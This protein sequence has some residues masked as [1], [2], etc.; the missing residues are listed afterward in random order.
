KMY[1]KAG[2]QNTTVDPKPSINEQLGR[3]TVTFE[4]VESTKVRIKKVNFEGNEAFSDKRLRKVIKTRSWNWLGWLTGAGKFKE[5]QFEEDKEKLRDFYGEN[6]YVDFEIKQVEFEFP[7]TN[8]MFIDFTVS[9]GSQFRVGQVT[10]EGN[11]VFPQGEIIANMRDDRGVMTRPRLVPGAIFTPGDLEKDL[12]GLQNFYGS[13]GYIDARVQAQKIPNVVARTIDLKYVIREGT[14]S[15]VEKIEIKGNTKTKDTVIRRELALSPGETFD[16]VRVKIS[17]QR[18]EQMNYF[19]KVDTKDDPTDAPGQRNLIVAVEEKNTGNI[20]L[21]AGYSSVDKL[22]G[23][24]E[25][26]QGNFDLFNPPNFTG[27]GQ[28]ARLRA[29]IGTQR[30]D[31]ILGFTEP[32]FLGR[33]LRLDTELYYRDLQYLSDNYT[34]TILGGSI[35]LTKQLPHNFTLNTTYTLQEVDII[36]NN[37]FLNSFATTIQNYEYLTN[38]GVVSIIGTNTT[39]AELPV[40]IQQAGKTLV[41]SLTW[42]LSHDTRNNLMLPTRGHLVQFEPMLA[43]GPLGGQADFYQLEV[44]AAQYWSPANLFSPASGTYDF[45]KEHILEIIGNVGVVSAYGDGDRGLTGVVPIFNRWYLG[46]MYSLRGFEFREVGPKQPL[47]GEPT[48]GGTYWFGSA[49]YSV[50]VVPRVRFAL[51]F[52]AGMV[53]PDSYSFTPQEYLD[54]TSTGFYNSNWG[55]GLRLNLPIG[56]LRLDYGIP[57]K[58]DQFND[59]GGRFQFGVGYTRDF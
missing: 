41:S 57:I 39:P 34:Q 35:G 22:V 26:T 30:Q 55:I 23:Y 29:Q 13:Q 32:W 2:M 17:K 42:S 53:Y 54:G 49:E 46:G 36:L 50:P 43:G 28:K 10:F 47:T 18:L 12:L 59:G 11:T 51:F 44:K 15:F 58:T 33:R 16:M 38:N 27:G 7:R 1:E 24:I 21:G 48:G 9:E 8:R 6:G 31:Y 52:D 20:A 3:G 14:K 25:V 4:I 40:F 19:E 45:F 37:A 5:D 56:P